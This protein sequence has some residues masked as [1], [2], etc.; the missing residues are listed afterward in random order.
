VL[1]IDLI[2]EF[3]EL[4]KISGIEVVNHQQESGHPFLHVVMKVPPYLV[5][6][7]GNGSEIVRLDGSD[8]HTHEFGRSVAAWTWKEGTNIISTAE[9][10]DVQMDVGD[11]ILSLLIADDDTPPDTLLGTMPFKVAAINDVPG[12][13]WHYYSAGATPLATL[14]DNLPANDG[15]FVEP[16]NDFQVKVQ[17]G[18]IGGSQF[19]GNI[20]AVGV[21]KI[22]LAAAGNYLFSTVGGQDSRIYIDGTLVTGP[23]VL[24]A[25]THQVEVRFSLQSLTELP[26]NLTVGLNG[27]AADFIDAAIISHDETA[28]KPFINSMP[29]TGLPAGGQELLIKGYGFF[30]NGAIVINWDG[31]PLDAANILETTPTTIRMVTPA[32]SGN[33][34]VSIETP[35]GSSNE[36]TYVYDAAAVNVTFEAPQTVA[37]IYKP[38][39][40]AWGPDGRLYI[41][42]VY[43]GEITALT[44]DDNYN[45]SS[46]QVIGALASFTNNNILGIAF[47]P[48]DPPSPVKI[49]VAHSQLFHDGGSCSFAGPVP[50]TG[51]VSTISGPAF[52]TVTP[53]VTGLPVSNHDH[54]VNGLEFDS[55][56]NLLIA[57]GGN[58]NAGVVDCVIG[59]LPESPLSG[60]IIKAEITKPG[61][62]GNIQYVERGTSI[63]NN[64]ELDGDIVEIAPGVDVSVYGH[65]LRNPFDL[66]WTTKDRLYSTDNGA[67]TGF[68][69]FST[70]ATTEEVATN[71]KDELNFI[72]SGNYFGHANRNRGVSDIRQNVY[73][74]PAD[75]SILGVYSAPLLDQFQ[76]S[77]NGIAEYRAKTFNDSMRGNIL[78]QY[79]DSHLYNVKLSND[80]RTVNEFVTI[81]HAPEALDVVTGPGGVILG[82]DH[83]GDEIVI[84]R[85][86]DTSLGVNMKAL[87]VFPWRAPAAGSTPFVIG[88][89]NFGTLGDTTVTFNGVNA[90]LTSVSATRIRG[91]IPA[92]VNPT[93][94]LVDVVINS[95]SQVS[96][97]DNAFRYLL[98]PGQGKGTWEIGPEAPLALGEVAGGAING[99]LYFVGEGSHETIAYDI[100]SNT[101]TSG[102]ADRP[103]AGDHHG[104]E[105][106]GDKLYIVGGIDHDDHNHDS[107]GKV[108]IYTPATNS[109]TLGTSIPFATGS[110]ST[111]VI[112]GKIYVAGGIVAHATVA[113]A[114]VYD[115]SGN[116]WLSIAD[117]P[118]GRNHAASASDGQKFYIFGGRGFG[119]GD[120]NVV[121]EG[122]ADVQ[123]YDPA[124]NTWKVSCDPVAPIAG[125]DATIPPLPQKR[126][127]MGKAVFFDG[128]FYIFGGET[129]PSGTGQVAGNVYNRVDVY[130]PVTKTWRL[131]APLPTARHG[132]FPILH[133]GRIYIALGGTVAAHSSSSILEIFRR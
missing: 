8:S 7:D 132:I 78:A 14:I 40:A 91:T 107:A 60:S 90:T 128:E 36:K 112:N 5:D 70:S 126:G 57:N 1:N 61:F 48:F 93:A 26:I 115:P 73:H 99:V 49:Y 16:K 108:Q 30:P 105:V 21:G 54:G 31:A 59:G 110:A 6:Y 84:L 51:Q 130:N 25:G 123:I 68:G 111:A 94:T 29:L 4:A 96:T 92:A 2:S 22:N 82:I 41:A 98:A 89:V 42:Q 119:S 24:T 116:S 43:T 46:T 104:A 32:G 34:T 113:S 37:N 103:N 83:S 129:L 117:M 18:K 75:V 69:A 56:G 87:D 95:D 80:G 118:A 88:G 35:N 71:E 27:G 81:N 19:T 45:V 17:G 28:T 11:Y 58:T 12:I 120:D 20:V 106:I 47:N 72:V 86:Q 23:R 101:W 15:N 66:V 133:D 102:L 67:N 76:S 131:E 53:L 9:V 52:N 100:Q 13:L 33:V 109:W 62:N 10:S 125:C 79:M 77:T 65:G 38:S 124:T 127:G 74:R 3:N 64:D 63:I 55:Q 114:A 39:Q 122:F 97:L 50:Y 44:F 85:P 121:A